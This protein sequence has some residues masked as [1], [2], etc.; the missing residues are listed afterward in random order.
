[1]LLLLLGALLLCACAQAEEAEDITPVCTFVRKT[2]SVDFKPLQ[3]RNYASYF[4]MNQRRTVE[5]HSPEDMSGVYLQFFRYTHPLDVQ[6]EQN[7]QWLPLETT[8]GA[9]LTAYVALPEGTR[10][11][12]IINNS[13]N[14]V[15]LAE[16]TLFGAG[17]MPAHIPPTASHSLRLFSFCKISSMFFSSQQSTCC[18]VLRKAVS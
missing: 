15:M 10:K 9:Y 12:R 16:V 2:S 11:L 6:I 14:Q 18:S 17:A 13:G 1:M 3:D 7:G 5:I 8:D 4:T